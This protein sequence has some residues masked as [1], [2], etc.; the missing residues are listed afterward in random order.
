M[1]RV[2]RLLAVGAL[3]ALALWAATTAV[4]AKPAREPNVIPTTVFPAGVACEGFPLRI[5][6]DVNQQHL[7]TFFDQDGN[8]VRQLI[9]GRLIITLTNVDTDSSVTLR[10]GGA[11]HVTINPDGSATL[12]GTGHGVLVLVPSDVPP[13]PSTTLRTGRTV[14]TISPEG[15]F[16]LIGTAGA[17]PLDLCAV[18]SS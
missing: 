13:G 1:T 5:S 11:T 17:E 18:L 7:T 16:T 15:A 3:V 12:V 14:L 9:T 4:A 8:P 6:A 10:L 2:N